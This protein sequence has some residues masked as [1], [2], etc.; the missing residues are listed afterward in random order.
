MF[1]VKKAM[2]RVKRR[3]K[4][5]KVKRITPEALFYAIFGYVE[6]GIA[7]FGLF[8][9]E[10]A[11]INKARAKRLKAINNFR[12]KSLRLRKLVKLKKKQRMY[13][14]KLLKRA[15]RPI[16]VRSIGTKTPIFD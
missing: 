3:T 2:R 16:P 6:Y 11:R 4:Y 14:G 12:K 8:L 9:A 5:K 10:L 13:K 1:A 15:R 7:A